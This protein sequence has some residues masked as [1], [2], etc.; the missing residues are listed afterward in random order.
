MSLI[1]TLNPPILDEAALGVAHGESTAKLLVR[2]GVSRRTLV[3]WKGRPDF[4]QRVADLRM[5][6]TS[7]AMGR[8]A[9]AANQ[10]ASALKRLLRSKNESIVLGAAKALLGLSGQFF[11]STQMQAEVEQLQRTI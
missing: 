6:T 7:R 2:L 11:T 3:R 9:A 10:G 1:G 5:E 8:A 4:R